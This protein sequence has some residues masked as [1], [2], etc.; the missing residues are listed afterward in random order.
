MYAEKM[1]REC[2]DVSMA[3]VIIE[4]LFPDYRSATL[5]AGIYHRSW[6]TTA[7]N[8]YRPDEIRGRLTE[9]TLEY[10]ADH[11][12]ASRLALLGS[13]SHGQGFCLVTPGESFLEL[14]YLFVEPEAFGT[15]LAGV[16]CEQAELT[17]M[18]ALHA[19]VL[20]GNERSRRFFVSRGWKE[21]A[22]AGQPDWAD[23]KA[24]VLFRQP[25]E[26]PPQSIGSAEGFSVGS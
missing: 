16:L 10:W 24:H 20:E 12:E 1:L 17:A 8:D 2:T 22:D 4:K 3:P 6:P 18:S 26:A 9:R 15:G 25:F 7:A 23:G 19:W 13:N 5:C 21:C 11:I 14:S